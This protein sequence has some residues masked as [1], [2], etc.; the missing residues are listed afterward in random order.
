[1]YKLVGFYSKTLTRDIGL[2]YDVVQHGPYTG[3]YVRKNVLMV[4]T[5]PLAFYVPVPVTDTY[6]ILYKLVGFYSKT[7]TRDI[8]LFYDVNQHGP[9]TRVYVRKNV[10]MIGAQPL[11]FYVPLRYTEHVVRRH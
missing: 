11:A 4:G 9:C 8:G 5:Q 1:M 6:L 2:F 3:V 7:L 10:S